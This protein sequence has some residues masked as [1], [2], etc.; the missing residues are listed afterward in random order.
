MPL[1]PLFYL[2]FFKRVINEANTMWHSIEQVI[3][4]TIGESFSIKH[5]REIPTRDINKCFWLSDDYYNFFI[6]INNKA[7]LENFEVQAYDLNKLKEFSHLSCP[8]VISFGVTLDKSY[9]ILNY[10]PLSKDNDTHWHQLGEQVALMH[11]NTSHG[12]FGW[13]YD[14]FLGGTLQ[15]N[16]WSSNWRTFFSEQ[17]IGWQLQLLKE[18]SISFGNN[19]HIIKVCHD[20]LLHHDVAPCLVHGDLWRKHM[21]FS[22]HQAVVLDPACYYGDR[23]VDIAM[24]ELYGQLPP[25]FY[26]AYHETF[27]LPESYQQRKL[28]YNFYHVLNHANLFGEQYLDQAKASLKR[29]MANS[30]H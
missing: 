22:G 7:Y 10:I 6:K 20:G 11:K 13:Q 24:T 8:E 15:P 5:K 2:Y 17:R 16:K 18:K 4:N 14:N 19:E 25:E 21:A 12:Q 30:I 9:L 3:S 1:F 29:I 28:I 26:Q 27:P 23:E